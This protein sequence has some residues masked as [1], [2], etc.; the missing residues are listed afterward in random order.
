MS[1]AF[2]PIPN[3]RRGALL[4]AAALAIAVL[5]ATLWISAR[6]ARASLSR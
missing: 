3:D 5:G 2:S 6:D 4:L 1:Y